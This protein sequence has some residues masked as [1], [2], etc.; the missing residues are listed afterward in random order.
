M[1]PS[2]RRTTGLLCALPGPAATVSAE[3]EETA[4]AIQAVPPC[5][6]GHRAAEAGGVGMIRNREQ[7]VCRKFEAGLLAFRT[8]QP[9]CGVGR[10]PACNSARPRATNKPV[11]AA[12]RKLDQQLER[13]VDPQAINPN[14]AFYRRRTESLLRR[15][16]RMALEVG[17]VP[18]CLPRE[19]IRARR[20]VRQKAGT[21]EDC[22]IFVHDVERCLQRLD[23]MH[24]EV[25]TRVALQEYTQR[26]ASHLLGVPQKSL[27]RWYDDAGHA[28]GLAVGTQF[29]GKE[30]LGRNVVKTLIGKYKCQKSDSRPD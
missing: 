28:F 26:E 7:K 22:V 25:L 6:Y 12:D 24:T 16:L 9:I 15:Y 13:T 19:A 30:Q 29:D 27:G 21:F 3:G 10:R 18:S 14:V 17:R 8:Q 23:R 4:R 11:E 2:A 5:W 1:G 20:S